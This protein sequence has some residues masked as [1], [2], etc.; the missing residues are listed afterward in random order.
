MTTSSGFTVMFF[1]TN[2]R[3]GFSVVSGSVTAATTTERRALTALP[4][5]APKRACAVVATGTVSG[6][7][8]RRVESRLSRAAFP[9]AGRGG[10]ASERAYP[11][12]MRINVAASHRSRAGTRV[13]TWTA[14]ATAAMADMADMCTKTKDGAG[15]ARARRVMHAVCRTPKSAF[16]RWPPT[17]RVIDNLRLKRTECEREADWRAREE[18]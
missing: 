12:P 9:A 7:T 8:G 3:F 17:R 10:D 14:G 15:G 2:L 13:R 11:H 4:D 6:Q 16:H 18:P 5:L 1:F